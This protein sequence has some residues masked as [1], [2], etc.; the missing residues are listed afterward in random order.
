MAV[1]NPAAAPLSFTGVFAFG[2]SLIDPGNDLKAAQRLSSFPFVNV[3]DGAPTAAN[4]YFLGRFTD[5]WNFADLVANKLI[6]APTQ[7][8]FPYGVTKSLLGIPVNG[9]RPDG[10]NLSFAYGGATVG[11]AGSPA[12]SLHDQTQ[13][14]KDFD[15]NPNA[16]H[17][18]SI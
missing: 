1:E 17:V 10:N 2:D 16:L 9:A 8:T 18:V 7:A 15:V 4:G 6:N 3:P 5:G 13:I 14:F 11:S 12:P